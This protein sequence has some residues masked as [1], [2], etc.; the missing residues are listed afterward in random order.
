[1]I[2]RLSLTIAITALVVAVLGATPVAGALEKLVLPKNTVGTAHLK[3]DAVT[4]IKVKNGSLLASDFKRGQLPAGPTGPAGPK[5]DKGD[6]GEAG[7]TNVTFRRTQVHMSAAGMWSSEAECRPNERLI[8]GGAGIVNASGYAMGGLDAAL[9]GSYPGAYATYAVADGERPTRW[10]GVAEAK[11]AGEA[12]LV[13]YAVC[14][15][16]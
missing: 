7:A 5:G 10:V 16:P 1:M 12:R 3:K 9:V 13:V 14:T 8:G 6:R 2:N 11:T 4:S 15:T